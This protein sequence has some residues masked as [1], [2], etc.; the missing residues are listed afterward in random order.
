[1]GYKYERSRGNFFS[2]CKK[3]RKNPSKLV[4]IMRNAGVY[5]S[6][7]YYCLNCNQWLWKVE[8]ELAVGVEQSF[9][10]EISDLI[11]F[12]KNSLGI[13]AETAE[14]SF[15]TQGYTE[16][17]E[18]SFATL[19]GNF[20]FKGNPDEIYKLLVDN[21]IVLSVQNPTPVEKYKKVKS[22]KKPTNGNGKGW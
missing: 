12:L 14:L 2:A 13:K 11:P 17:L 1:M 21:S 18:E 5:T 7:T 8:I 15:C 20:T 16:D 19:K 3:C 6:G 9:L 10:S 4:L 22:Q